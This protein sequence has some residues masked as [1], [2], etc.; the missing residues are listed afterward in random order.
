[1]IF[2][3]LIIPLLLAHRIFRVHRARQAPRV[4][5]V[6]MTVAEAVVGRVAAVVPQGIGNSIREMKVAKCGL[7]TL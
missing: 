7:H 2:A 5:R 1:M 6:I 3:D 4:H